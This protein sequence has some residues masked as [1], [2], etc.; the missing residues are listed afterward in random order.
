MLHITHSQC[1]R[2]CC[3]NCHQLSSWA[4]IQEKIR[5]TGFLK[6]ISIKQDFS[7]LHTHWSRK[8]KCSAGVTGT[9]VPEGTED[10][11]TSLQ[12]VTLQLGQD[13]GIMPSFSS[14]TAESNTCPI[15]VACLY[16]SQHREKIQPQPAHK[17][18]S[19]KPPKPC[20]SLW[21]HLVPS[22]PLPFHGLLPGKENK[23]QLHISIPKKG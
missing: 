6:S 5:L 20:R 4:N 17:Q 2:R 9:S 13:V 18:F 19:L 21:S 1:F 22:R 10:L 3:L 14:A 12:I 15:T 23:A 16:S 7:H 8:T 11:P